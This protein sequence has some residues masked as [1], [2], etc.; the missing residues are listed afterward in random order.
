MFMSADLPSEIQSEVFGLD[1]QQQREVLAF[2]R[3]LKQ[4]ST[5]ISGAELKGLAGT[6]GVEDADAMTRAIEAG[7]EQVDPDGW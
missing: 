2:V 4:Q 1:A 3:D 6:L 7:C 5:G